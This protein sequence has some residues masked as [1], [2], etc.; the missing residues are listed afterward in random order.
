MVMLGFA[1]ANRDAAEFPDPDT[2]NPERDWGSHVAFGFGTHYCLG[3]PLARVEASASL[4]AMLDRYPTI[5]RGEG[6]ALRINS[7]VLRGFSALP[8]RVSGWS[9][10][11]CAARAFASAQRGARARG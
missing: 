11:V 6:E 9:L 2:F 4:N 5:Q 8:L 1:S 3:S 7:P 10:R